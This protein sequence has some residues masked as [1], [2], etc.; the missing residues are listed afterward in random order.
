M[1]RL[2]NLITGVMIC[3]CIILIIPLFTG[4]YYQHRFYRVISTPAIRPALQLDGY[5]RGWFKS[6]ATYTLS[7]NSS[8]QESTL[9]QITVNDHISHGPIVYD[10][11]E[12]R[13]RFALAQ[14]TSLMS[15]KYGETQTVFKMNSVITLNGHIFT[16]FDAPDI[17]LNPGNKF[18]ITL[19]GVKINFSANLSLNHPNLVQ[20]LVTTTLNGIQILRPQQPEISLD[21]SSILSRAEGSYLLETP[22]ALL[23]ANHSLSIKSISLSTNN[24]IQSFIIDEFDY[25]G[26]SRIS[27]PDLVSVYLH[28][29]LANIRNPVLPI[30]HSSLDISLENLSKQPI[31]HVKK[32]LNEN[33]DG[34]TFIAEKDNILKIINTKTALG[35]LLHI[36]TSYG[37]LKTVATIDW[38]NSATPQENTDYAKN[39]DVHLF[40][41]VSASLIDQLLKTPQLRGLV[42]LLTETGQSEE[43]KAIAEILQ[44]PWFSLM[45][46][47][48]VEESIKASNFVIN[49]YYPEHRRATTSSSEIKKLDQLKIDS[50]RRLE[51]DKQF[52]ATLDAILNN[53]KYI[54]QILTK[55]QEEIR[56]STGQISDYKKQILTADSQQKPMLQMKIQSSEAT[57][58]VATQFLEAFQKSH[59]GSNQAVT[60]RPA[61]GIRENSN[62]PLQTT[63]PILEQ[64]NKLISKKYIIKDQTDY[65]TSIHYFNGVLEVNGIQVEQSLHF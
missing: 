18:R 35:T 33:P 23:P 58:N 64:I 11:V 32:M 24:K 43:D 39:T 56:K 10:P 31:E 45:M 48:Q 29:D 26:Q 14:I 9:Y 65:V 63:D 52:L 38:G 61:Q 22:E 57:L 41:R 25:T 42:E 59:P 17:T 4:K 51:K 27:E 13:W 46:R 34:K 49:D 8:R 19:N 5:Q 36:N 1:P 20:Y 30:S 54:Q 60:R 37:A 44:H 16:T 40:M 7:E 2:I 28:S 62:T 55:T 15:F 53:P 21:L 12:K 3:L 50:I 47:R 6:D